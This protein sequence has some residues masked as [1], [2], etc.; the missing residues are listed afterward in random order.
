MSDNDFYDPAHYSNPNY[1]E[2]PEQESEPEYEQDPDECD[3]E[4]EEICCENCNE[5]LAE[6]EGDYNGLCEECYTR[7]HHPR[8]WEEQQAEREWADRLNETEDEEEEEEDINEED[9]IVLEELLDDNERRIDIQNRIDRSTERR[10]LL[11]V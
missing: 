5:F 7:T 9:R 1:E 4:E 3:F 8:I 6:C 11:V 10:R 2:P